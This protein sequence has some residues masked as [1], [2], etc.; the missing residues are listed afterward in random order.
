ML[1]W[2]IESVNGCFAMKTLP[3]QIAKRLRQDIVSGRLAPGTRLP[4][5]GELAKHYDASLVTVQAA[6]K[7]LIEEGFVD[8]GARMHGS[9]VAE[10]PPHLHHY[11]LLFPYDPSH[12]GEFWR[13][14]RDQAASI[15]EA[16]ER[17]F[18]FFYG[19][20]GHRDIESYR[21]LVEDVRSERVA[22]LIFASG[23]LEFKGT[24]ILDQPGIPR[25]ALA[26]EYE[27]PG[28]PRMH[29]DHASFFARALDALV[30]QGRRRIAVLYGSS[31]NDSNSEVEKACLAAMTERGLPVNPVWLQFADTFSPLSAR[32]CLHLMLQRPVKD[33]PDGLILADDNFIPS[34]IQGILES[35]VQVPEELAVVALANFPVGIAAAVPVTR[36]GFDHK[37]MLETLAGWIDKL[38]DGGQPPKFQTVPAIG[39]DEYQ[40]RVEQRANDQ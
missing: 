23:A 2:A 24:P 28:M 21:E 10:R 9:F 11:K 14:L 12:R 36:I 30:A 1:P 25:V 29:V 5:R 18:S 4:N 35:G 38:R 16:S 40:Q 27:L 15:A 8:V 13:V 20:G 34:A 39:E 19:L 37:A 6:V 33:R 22:G 32:R 17:E 26:A 7:Y 31:P 3:R